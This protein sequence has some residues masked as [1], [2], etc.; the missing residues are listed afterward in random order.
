MR[1]KFE[2]SKTK[3][4]KISKKKLI[5]QDIL[6]EFMV[7]Q[8]D[9]NF[10]K[11]EEIL[12]YQ[13]TQKGRYN[14]NTE[15]SIKFDEN[16]I[17]DFSELLKSNKSVLS[18]EIIEKI[19]KYYYYKKE[20]QKFKGDTIILEDKQKEETADKNQAQKNN[21][22]LGLLEKEKEIEKEKEKEKEIVKEVNFE[23]K[24]EELEEKT[25]KEEKN[26]V[27]LLPPIPPP[28]SPPIGIPLSPGI[29]PPP[30]GI[31]GA[32]IFGFQNGP[33]PTKEK[34]KLKTK[35]KSLQWTRIIL[36]KNDSTD[37]IW[38]SIT[39]PDIDQNEIISLFESKNK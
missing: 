18:Q 10:K 27:Q 33:Q 15:Q 21:N 29:P 25:E 12:C 9:V 14:E 1:K 28:P 23:S 36:D 31:P 2:E 39:E 13:M 4:E 30:T 8:N 3:N 34:I 17:L 38:K 6:N 26:Q 24:K 7:F 37:L 20:S 5:L 35:V 32:P 19:E 16:G 11:K 22:E